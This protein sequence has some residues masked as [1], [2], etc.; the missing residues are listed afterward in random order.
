[1]R[2]VALWQRLAVTA[3]VLA[4]CL[5]V[6]ACKSKVTV[7][8]FAKVKQGMSEKEVEGILGSPSKSGEEDVP[9]MGKLKVSTWKS[10]NSVVTVGYKDG[11][12]F[13]MNGQFKN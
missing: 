6:P 9:L 11:K 8:N 1:M 4:L 3:L 13:T 10:G 2:N 12:V 5:A 7:D